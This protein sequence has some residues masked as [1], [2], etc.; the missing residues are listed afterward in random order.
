MTHVVVNQYGRYLD[1]IG[2]DEVIDAI[3]HDR[4]SCMMDGNIIEI[5]AHQ[6]DENGNKVTRVKVK[7]L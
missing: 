5:V 1:G 7:G 4:T 3:M 2:R 6:V